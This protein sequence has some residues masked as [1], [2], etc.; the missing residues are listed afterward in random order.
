MPINLAN[1]YILLCS[2]TKP[3]FSSVLEIHES[4]KVDQSQR[5]LKYETQYISASVQYHTAYCSD[6]YS[7]IMVKNRRVLRINSHLGHLRN[8][9]R[10]II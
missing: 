9:I 5:L 4:L 6:N 7:Y 1:P 2:T 10:T 8:D 3:N